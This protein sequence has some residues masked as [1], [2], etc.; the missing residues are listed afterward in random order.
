MVWG[1]KDGVSQKRVKSSWTAIIFNQVKSPPLEIYILIIK[2][3]Q[4]EN[5]TGNILIEKKYLI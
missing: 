2:L 5:Y 3:C 1:W 4:T